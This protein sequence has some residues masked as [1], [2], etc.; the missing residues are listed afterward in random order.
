MTFGDRGA[1]KISGRA[2][3]VMGKGVVRVTDAES[4]TD[5]D[6]GNGKVMVW[7]MLKSLGVC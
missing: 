1:D 3:R 4:A 2:M 6:F 5:N 7:R